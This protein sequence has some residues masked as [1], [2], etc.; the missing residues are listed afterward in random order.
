LCLHLRSG[1]ALNKMTKSANTGV[2]MSLQSSSSAQI[3]QTSTHAVGASLPTALGATM[4]MPVSTEMGVTTPTTAL[5]VTAKMTQPE[6]GIFVPPF[7][8]GVPVSTS[9]PT[10]TDPQVRTI[11]DDKVINTQNS[12][13]D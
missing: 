6:M 7:T 12:S 13:K 8:A 10:S 3:T 2:S 5:I 9:V 11:F 4:A 1:K